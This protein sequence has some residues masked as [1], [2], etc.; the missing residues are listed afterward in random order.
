[1][2]NQH[3]SNYIGSCRSKPNSTHQEKYNKVSD[4]NLC[5][6]IHCFNR[7]YNNQP[8]PKKKNAKCNLVK[9]IMRKQEKKKIEEVTFWLNFLHRIYI[10][11]C[12]EW[13]GWSAARGF[14]RLQESRNQIFKYR[15]AR[16]WEKKRLSI[17]SIIQKWRIN[18]IW[19]N[20]RLGKQ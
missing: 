14:E 5:Y 8:P 19:R 1:M 10:A 3:S 7:S 18:T 6:K 15:A 17:D 4:S 11:C 2:N 16:K 9:Y 12:C 20:V 13:L